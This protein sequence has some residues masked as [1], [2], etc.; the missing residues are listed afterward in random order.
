MDK[1]EK[2]D[3][4][5][6][7]LDEGAITQEEF[8][9]EKQD[10]LDETEEVDRSKFWGMREEEYSMFMH[11]SQML[12][13]IIPFGG[14]IMPLVMWATAKDYSETV[15]VH[16]RHIFNWLLSTLIYFIVAF[17]LIFVLIGIPLLVALAV[18]NVIFAIIGAIKARNGVTWAYPMAIPFFSK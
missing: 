1:Y 13:F 15:D 7:L 12:G 17:I 3:K 4:L 5:K 8:D 18:V 6:K 16:G 9:A 14:V 2:I 11:L 10:I